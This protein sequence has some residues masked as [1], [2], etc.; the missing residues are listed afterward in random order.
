M[1]G[2]DEGETP[3]PRRFAFTSNANSIDNLPPEHRNRA[4][5]A[6]ERHR[7][8]TVAGTITIRLTGVTPVRGTVTCESALERAAVLHAAAAILARIP[9]AVTDI[10]EQP[11]TA[12]EP[13]LVTVEVAELHPPNGSVNLTA[14]FA[15]H[16]FA[17]AHELILA[18]AG[19]AP[20]LGEQPPRPEQRLRNLDFSVGTTSDGFPLHWDE[21]EGPATY[22]IDANGGPG[23]SPCLEITCESR[24]PRYAAV[25][26]GISA[27]GLHGRRLRWSAKLAARRVTDGGG[28]LSILAFGPTELVA[29][30]VAPKAG[31]TGDADW[32]DHTA[33]LHVPDAARTLTLGCYLAARGTLVAAGFELAVDALAATPDG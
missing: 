13:A 30:A 3:A 22:R 14:G 29:A 18:E 27:D 1:D 10:A 24:P 21:D 7:A 6:L 11:P 12:Q 28:H 31:V 9:A 33:E 4:L 8:R 15:A 23:G 2:R 17:G 19:D 26:Q 20:P 32:T 25:Y 5:R 16:A